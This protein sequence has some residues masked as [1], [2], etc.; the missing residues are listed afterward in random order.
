MRKPKERK[1]KDAELMDEIEMSFG[2]KQET[3][4]NANGSKIGH[5]RTRT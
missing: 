2:K 1:K 3:T 5:K 4:A